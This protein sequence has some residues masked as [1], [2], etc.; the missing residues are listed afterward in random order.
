LLWPSHRYNFYHPNGSGRDGFI[1]HVSQHQTT[2]NY[3]PK[4]PEFV[5]TR[6]PGMASNMVGLTMG[7]SYFDK[8]AGVS[9]YTGH[10]VPPSGSWGE[11]TPADAF[12]GLPVGG[13]A[14]SPCKALVGSFH[15]E[16]Q[17]HESNIQHPGY[18]VPGYGGHC[19]GQQ[20][21][22]GFTHGAI[23]WG[24]AG[25]VTHL[26]VIGPGAPGT[27]EREQLIRSTNLQRG[28]V[29]PAGKARTKMGYTGHL[30]GKHY[31]TNFGE[32]FAATAEKLLTSTDA[33][34]VKKEGEF[35][36][37]RPPLLQAAVS[38]YSGFRPRTTPEAIFA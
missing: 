13:C 30:G 36:G 38:G 29:L 4:A 10:L 25:A 28:A 7:P 14:P 22:C 3:S 26:G 6:M 21:A 34:Y 17:K 11:P 12:P 23:C 35:P 19:T 8:P 15:E 5:G 2:F 18:R 27:T 9:G 1:H 20:H 24:D 37:A 33:G 32:S 31:S 16:K